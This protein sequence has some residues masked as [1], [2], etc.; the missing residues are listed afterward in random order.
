MLTKE[1]ITAMSNAA[2]VQELGLQYRTYRLRAHLT[3]Q[4]VATHAGVSLLTL[5]AFEQGR[6]TNITMSNFLSLLRTIGQL[7]NMA[8]V[9]PDVPISPYLLSE[10]NGRLPK[11]IRHGK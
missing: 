6:A 10:L 2:I 4:E 9:L 3:Q 1:N 11:R 5:R 8:E 7:G